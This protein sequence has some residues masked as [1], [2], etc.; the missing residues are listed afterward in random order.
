MAKVM[1]VVRKEAAEKE[2]LEML[3]GRWKLVDADD[4][5]GVSKKKGF[6]KHILVIDD[7]QLTFETE[8]DEKDERGPFQLATT[9]DPKWIDLRVGGHDRV[10]IYE[11]DGDRLKICFSS[12]VPLDLSRRPADFAIKPGSGRVLHVYERIK[13][14]GQGAPPAK[15]QP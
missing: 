9:K 15:P 13:K 2:C 14:D 11:V 8:P 5:D 4:S 10:G 1:E 3:Q 6:V 7:K 12:V